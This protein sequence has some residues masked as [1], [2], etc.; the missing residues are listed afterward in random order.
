MMSAQT[1]SALT[2]EYRTQN[3]TMSQLCDFLC[4]R[5]TEL[6]KLVGNNAPIVTRVTMGGVGGMT[7]NSYSGKV[8]GNVGS[9]QVLCEI[10]GGKLV[11]IHYKR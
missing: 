1:L 10:D 7:I 2:R 6:E 3:I 9:Q 4:D 11:A 8:N 5:C